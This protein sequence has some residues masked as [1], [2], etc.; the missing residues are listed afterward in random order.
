M[1]KG[2]KLSGT[3][4]NKTPSPKLQKQTNFNFVCNTNYNNFLLF[5]I[6]LI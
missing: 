5:D 4:N 1:E 2:I 3:K 6:Y